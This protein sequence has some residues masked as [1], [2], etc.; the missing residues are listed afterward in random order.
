MKTHTYT[1]TTEWTGNKG[2]GTANYRAYDRN[3]TVSIDNKADI[4]GSSDPVFRGDAHKHNP[5]ELLLAALS[6]CHLLWYLHL[7]AEVGIIV[8]DYTDNAQG[9]MVETA[10]GGGRFTQVML[11]PSV[12][13]ADATMIEMAYAL[14]K[15]ANELCFIAKSVNF[16]VLHQPVCVVSV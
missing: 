6:S 9:L 2:K 12:R 5:E 13:V 1:L 3:Y 14:H 15:R 11:C 10:D 4:L 8:V 16:P 7:C